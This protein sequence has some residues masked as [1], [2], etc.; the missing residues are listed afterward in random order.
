[1]GRKFPPHQYFYFYNFLN[2]KI[3]NKEVIK[4]KCPK[5]FGD[6]IS[7]IGESHYVCNNPLCSD[8]NGNRVQFRLVIDDKVRFPYN[9]IFVDRTKNEFYRKPYLQLE[10]VGSNNVTR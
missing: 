7:I 4:M 8:I 1:M 5:C 3:K 9:Q 6:D 10:E 2:N